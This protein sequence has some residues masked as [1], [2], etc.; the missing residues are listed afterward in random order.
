MNLKPL[1]LGALLAGC[2]AQPKAN[3]PTDEA[4]AQAIAD[5]CKEWVGK[6]RIEAFGNR[7]YGAF[8]Y[9]LANV[10]LIKT[11]AGNLYVDPGLDAGFSPLAT[12]VCL[13]AGTPPTYAT[14]LFATDLVGTMRPQGVAI[15]V[16]A[17]PPPAHHGTSLRRGRSETF[18]DRGVA[19]AHV[20]HASL[21]GLVGG[22]LARHRFSLSST[23]TARSRHA[24]RNRVA[25]SIIGPVNS[26]PASKNSPR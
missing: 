4:H 15:D 23:C 2:T 8:G 12:S 11:S 1:V 21:P 13:D 7:V 9:D 16:G 6:P 24:A 3:V 17:E 18:E 5:R 22:P 19:R 25:A 26:W 14:S 10:F 20:A